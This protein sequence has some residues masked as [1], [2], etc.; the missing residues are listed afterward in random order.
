VKIGRWPPLIRQLAHSL[1]R[2]LPEGYPSMDIR[3]PI[4]PF[5]PPE[6]M[7]SAARAEAID[8]IAAAPASLRAAVAGLDDEQLDTPYRPGGWTVRQVVHHVPDS[9][10]NAYIR[11][12]LALTEDE[13]TIKPYDQAA[14][15]R[16]PD[17]TGPIGPSLDLLEALHDRWVRL[18]G[19]L[20]ERDFTRR[21]NHPENGIITN[22][23][24]LALY[25][26]HGRHHVGHVTGL[27]DRMGW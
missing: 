23:F 14:W 5:V 20:S 9:H 12:K 8:A 27:R 26:W 1:N 11:M 19:E 16:L 24:L 13:P 7:T 3:Y 17:S 22:D 10:L 4:G 2:Q 21:L 25:A 6:R 15:A 18:L